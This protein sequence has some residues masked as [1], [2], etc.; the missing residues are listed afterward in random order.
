MFRVIICSNLCSIFYSFTF[1]IYLRFKN[2]S[3]VS[4]L[5]IVR[6]ETFILDQVFRVYQLESIFPSIEPRLCNRGNNSPRQK[7]LLL[8]PAE[9]KLDRFVRNEQS[10]LNFHF[11]MITRLYFGSSKLRK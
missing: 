11:Q 7:S 4:L 6:N 1:P 5:N 3:L 9:L 2:R 8:L 10:H